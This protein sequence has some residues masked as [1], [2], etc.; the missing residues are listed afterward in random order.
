[1]ADLAIVIVNYNTKD[2]LDD[3]L[4]T[5]AASVYSF[6]LRVVV[7]DNHSTDASIEMVRER[8][9]WVQVIAAE[10]NGGYAYANNI[11]LRAMGFENDAVESPCYALLL[12]PDTLLPP[13]ALQHVFE[14]AEANPDVGVVGPKLVRLDGSLDKA[15]RRS[16]PT[17]RVSAFHMLYLDR[18]FPQSKI[19]AR[20]NLSF[21]DVDEQ[22]DV[23]SVV[24]AFM[25]MRRE[26][27]QDVGL[28]DEAFFMYGEDLDLCYRI[29]EAGWRVVYYPRTVV[30]HIKG[31]A[32]SKRSTRSIDA[33]YEAMR[34]FHRK[35]YRQQTFFL[36]NWLIYAGIWLKHHFSLAQ[37]ALRPDDRKHV[38]SA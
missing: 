11:G 24:G 35:Y 7:V 30:T 36:L 5:L 6:E 12:N 21:L 27:L 25:F 20:Y 4:C 34:I 1:M 18:L 19:F 22:V 8:H 17:P 28:L 9:P 32:S 15:C 10:R 31:A 16:F 23:D 3:C 29:K 13:D 33:F 37:N 26:A 14:F 38:A 2:E